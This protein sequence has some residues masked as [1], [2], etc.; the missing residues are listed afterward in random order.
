MKPAKQSLLSST[1]DLAIN[2]VFLK[3][4]VVLRGT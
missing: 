3:P 1:L 4:L 2:T